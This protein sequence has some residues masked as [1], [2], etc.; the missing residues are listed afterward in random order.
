MNFLV[1]FF[2][3]LGEGDRV[4]AWIA[5]WTPNILFTT[6]GLYLLYLRASNREPP[7]F[8]LFAARRTVAR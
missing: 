3:A 5:A 2:L 4:P 6:I 8:H 7:S 1:H